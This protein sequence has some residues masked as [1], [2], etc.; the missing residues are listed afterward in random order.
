MAFFQTGGYGGGGVE[1]DRGQQRTHLAFEVVLDPG[2]LGF[3]A[4]A[5]AHDVD[6]LGF[7]FRQHGRIEDFVLAPDQFM[8]LVADPFQRGGQGRVV[9]QVAVDAGGCQQAGHPD[10][11][12]LVEIAADNA[13]IAQ[14]FEHGDGGVFRLGHHAAVERQL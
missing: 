11:K 8:A 3:V 2:P 1:P 9:F 7:H 13:E 4:L 10:F 14:S 5:V 12:E 6:T